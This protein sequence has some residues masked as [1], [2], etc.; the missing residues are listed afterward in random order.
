MSDGWMLTDAGIR[1]VEENKTR[2]D[3][4]GQITKDHRQQSMQFLRK[5]KNHRVFALYEKDPIQY[6]PSIG[7]LADLLRCRVDAHD[8]VWRDRFEKIRKNAVAAG[9]NEF[10][11]F[12]E[13]S[14]EAYEASVRNLYG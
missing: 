12:V 8:S 3:A 6:S 11:G 10:L 2:F 1:W 4:V 13:K 9:Q 7:D 5:I 14:I